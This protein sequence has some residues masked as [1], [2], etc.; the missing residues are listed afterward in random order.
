MPHYRKHGKILIPLTDEE[1]AEG[2][3]NGHFVQRKHKGFLALIHYTGIRLTEA[4][5]ARKEQ[6]NLSRGEIVF[7]VGKRL[8]RGIET[9]PLNIPLETP[10]AKEIWEAVED[11]KPSERVWPYCDKTGYNIVDRVFKY[12]HYH[13]LSRIT[14]FFEQGY[15]I[16]K[17]RSWTGL[18][19]KALNFYVGIVDVKEMGRA[20]K[21]KE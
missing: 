11:T 20:L 13:R 16:S 12:P 5:R 1:F 21:P 7:D 2:M 6:F 10:Y 18:S 4:L 17:V 15:P 3:K 19:L 9:P 14:W 8:K